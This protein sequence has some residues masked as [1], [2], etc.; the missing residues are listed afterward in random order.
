MFTQDLR[1]EIPIKMLP[2]SAA[3][4]P[5]GARHSLVNSNCLFRRTPGGYRAP[6][7]GNLDGTAEVFRVVL[8]RRMYSLMGRWAIITLKHTEG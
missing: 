5:T 3:R 6:I 2:F 1:P 8:L 4:F 7:V